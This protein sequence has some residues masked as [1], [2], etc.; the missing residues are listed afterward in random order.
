PDGSRLAYVPTV[1]G[2]RVLHLRSLDQ[3]EGTSIPGTEE[4]Y[5]PFFSPDSN[6]VGYVTRTELKKVSVSG[7]TPLTLCELSL[8]RGASW[9]DDDTIVLA[10]SA[11]SGLVRVPA[12]GGEPTPLTTLDEASG[13]VTHRWPFALP[14]GRGVLFTSHNSGSNFDSANIEVID[15]TTGERKVLHRGGS[16]PQYVPTG[17]LVY[18]NEGTLFAADFDLDSLEVTSQ[19]APVVQN[20][21]SNPAGTGGAQISFSRNGTLA[22]LHG[23]ATSLKHLMVWVD[24]EGQWTPVSD[25]LETFVEPR[26]SPDGRSLAVEIL[27]D[28][29]SDAWVYDLER[30]AST[31]LTFHEALDEVPIWSPDGQYIVFSSERDGAPNLY[32]KRSDG[33]GQVERLTT[34]EISQYPTSWSPDGEYVLFAQFDPQNREDLW[35][36]PIGSE[37]EPELYLQTPFGESEGDFSPDGRWIAYSSDESGQHEVYVRPFPSGGGKWQISVGGGDKPRWSQEGD[38]IFYRN[39]GGV[40]V[41]EVRV[42]RDALRAEKPR[43]L[44]NSLFPP[45]TVG[46]TSYADYDVDPSGE[47]FLMFKPEGEQTARDHLIFVTNWFS[48]LEP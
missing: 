3:L 24:R 27:S 11:S 26:L 46:G 32:R 7:G 21:S 18:M 37:G 16:Y 6:W 19:P 43:Q 33:S 31:K 1:G 4:A 28:N 44:F 30:G 47:R 10:P 40:S 17:H 20:I 29:G 2:N 38:A 41:A 34:S 8:S 22:Y 12:A 13:E 39:G 48:E 5:N 45:L 14:G 25:E 23:S 36:L 9:A 15:T 35:V 42:D